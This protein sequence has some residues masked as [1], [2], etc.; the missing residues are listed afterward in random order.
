MKMS[1]VYPVWWDTSLTIYN[2]HEDKQTHVVTWHRTIIDNCFWKYVW[3]RALIGQ[4]AVETNYIIC[5]IPKDERF[6]DKYLWVELPNDEKAGR[7]TLGAGDLIVRGK[8]DEE[9]N[10]HVSG[11]RSSDFL[12]KYKKLQG[13]ME[14]REVA[15]D[16]GAGRCA[17]HYRVNGI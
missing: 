3:D 1:N 5:R 2:R 14:I 6:M 15:I 11:M 17:E 7:F 16:V 10:E 13:C 9:I 8:V 12:A 4:T